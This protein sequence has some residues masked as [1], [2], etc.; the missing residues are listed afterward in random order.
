M[1]R[2]AFLTSILSPAAGGLS[3]SVPNLVRA[4]TCDESADVHVVGLEDPTNPGA[5][6][7]WGP[8]VHAHKVSGPQA[9][10][11]APRLSGTLE[12]LAPQI[13]DVQGLWMYPSVASLK[14]YRRTGT[15]YVVTPRGMLDPWARQNSA[16]K[17]KA[18]RMLFEDAHLAG[19]ACLRATAEM[20]AEHFRSFGLRNP[21]AIVPNGVDIPD[22]SP[23][24]RRK[25]SRR[26]ALFLSRIHPKKGLPYLLKAWRGI[27]QIRP[28][29]E[30]V[31]AGP[32][33]VGHTAEM[34]QM[35]SRLGLRRVI[36]HPQVHG[37]EKSALYRSADL[38]VLPTHA[39]NFGLVIAEAL[40]HEVPVITTTNSPWKG[41]EEH[42]CGWWIPLEDNALADCMVAATAKTRDELHFM[43]RI[44]QAW[45]AQQFGWDGIAQQMQQVYEWLLRRGKRPSFVQI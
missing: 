15:P 32:D 23:F 45:M 31:V 41:L 38:F 40:A 5:A 20:E 42:S 34:Q 33:E 13:I 19:A 37:S 10:G 36:W 27:E 7:Q 14:H 39:E 30:L 18:V 44:G 17:K 12:R 26:R 22:L 8:H 16:W 4:L 29:W 2:Y 6:A 9:F 24:P 35:A 21:I 3:A 1:T 28:N 25:G 43:G 11:Y